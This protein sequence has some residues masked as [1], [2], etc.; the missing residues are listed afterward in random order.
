LLD[1][2]SREQAQA[3]VAGAKA[4]GSQAKAQIER[5]KA[6]LAFAKQEVQRIRPLVER[7][8]ES[9][10]TLQ[11]ATLDV[12]TR[13]AELT[14]AKFASRVAE[15][16]E[17]VAR[18]AFGRLDEGA[19]GDDS[20]QLELTSPIQGR[21]LAVRHESGGVTAA[22]TPLLELGDPTALEIVVDVLTRDAVQIQRGAPATI[23]RWGGDTLDAKVRLVEPSA[24]TRVS[25]LG[26][27]EQRVNVILD[28]EQP[29]EVWA[30]LG[31]GYRIEANITIWQADDVVRVPSSAL[32]RHEDAWAVF[33]IDGELAKLT[34]V[35][36]GRR[37][38]V[39][40]EIVSGL[41]PGTRVI[42]HPSDRVADGATVTWHR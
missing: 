34:P 5:A 35:E 9:S 36:V 26:V 10:A 16:E 8:I 7:G 19:T 25:S 15:H 12:D 18:L 29:Y 11:R 33:A 41:E 21:V 14:S 30:S 31:E 27:E 6:A 38:T 40:A 17:Q 20:E 23:T 39:Q 2:R 1:A 42:V 32:F 22:G 3:R 13:Q 4:A 24:F 37:S 28:L